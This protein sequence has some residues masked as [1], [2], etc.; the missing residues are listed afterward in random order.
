MNMKEN[1]E[2]IHGQFKRCS[3]LTDTESHYSGSSERLII[4]ITEEDKKRDREWIKAYMDQYPNGDYT[5]DFLRKH[6]GDGGK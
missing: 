4:P 3:V 1:L 2:G 5:G 6:E